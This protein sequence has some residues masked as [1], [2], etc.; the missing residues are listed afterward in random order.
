MPVARCLPCRGKVAQCE[1]MRENSARWLSPGDSSSIAVS[2][3]TRFTQ[4]FGSEPTGV[5]FAP[6]RANLNG[7]HIDFHGG[8][9]LPMAL[10]HGTYVAATPRTDGVLRLRTLDARLDSGVV[11]IPH[12]ASGQ[13]DNAP[14]WTRYVSGVL[15]AMGRLDACTNDDEVYSDLALDD[16]FGA[17]VL[18]RST[19]PIGGGL[20]SSASLEC[21]SALA[22]AALGSELGQDNPKDEFTSALSDAHRA[23]LAKACIRAEVEAVGAGTGGLDQT[24]S[25]RAAENKLISLDCRTFSLKRT[26]IAFLMREYQLL[27]VDTGQPHE[28]ADG[29]FSQR[30]RES[31]AAAAVLGVSRLRDALPEKPRRADMDATLAEYDQ[32]IEDGAS[33]GGQDPESC[34]KRLVH[35]L[36]EM[37]RSDKIDK[38]LTGEAH[39]VDDTAAVI[40]DAMAAGHHSMRD[41]AEVSFDL[42]DQVVDVAL[43]EGASGARLIGGGF[44]GS[45]L[46]LAP[47]SR[48]ETITHAVAKLS[49]HIRFLAV[50]PSSPAHAVLV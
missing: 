31:D 7:E 20:S 3:A 37:M 2:L 34:R 33:L 12:A 6:G 48:L 18:I 16:G 25:M 22:F 46:V 27:A 47:K 28:L 42:A 40:G 14:D 5:W 21:A 39:G 24:T 26:N 13:D 11:E 15:W 30:R 43:S 19:L 49:P 50:A 9:C 23:A 4:E 38:L 10:S 29:E 44:G 35:A 32:L 17:D 41:L 45:V 36:T 8:R 1:P